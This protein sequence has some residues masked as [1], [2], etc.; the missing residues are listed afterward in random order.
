VQKSLRKLEKC[1]ERIKTEEG[2]RNTELIIKGL[3]RLGCFMQDALVGLEKRH[4]A[5]INQLK[6][7]QSTRPVERVQAMSQPAN[8]TELITYPDKIDKFTVAAAEK[9]TL[10]DI[11]AK[12]QNLI[13]YAQDSK[14]IARL[15]DESQYIAI[16]QNIS[17]KIRQWST[18][19]TSNGLWIEGPYDSEWPSHSALTSAFVLGTLQRLQLPT[20]VYFLRYD[21]SQY[22]TFSPDKELVNI[23]YSLIYQASQ[24]LTKV[25]SESQREISVNAAP[26]DQLDGKIGSL[27]VAIDLLKE[28]ISL[29]EVLQFCIIDGIQVLEGKRLSKYGAQYL[30]ELL[31]LLGGVSTIGSKGSMIKSLFSTNGMMDGL[32]KIANTGL[33]LRVF[34]EVEDEDDSNSLDLSGLT[35]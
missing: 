8:T 16:G 25:S 10:E 11:Q 27:S 29:G 5:H 17:M 31:G 19:L 23:V 9:L 12:V 1:T 2:R 28:L 13:G 33:L 18:S 26:F 32:A 30:D 34:D 4:I 24:N 20:M 21:A 15:R 6:A 3:M 35:E 14:L 7:E 22:K